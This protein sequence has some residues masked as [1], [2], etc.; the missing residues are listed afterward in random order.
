MK[1]KLLFL[2]F[3]VSTILSIKGNAQVITLDQMT[4]NNTSIPDCSNIN[5]NTD[6][7]VNLSFKLKVTKSN[8]DNIENGSFKHR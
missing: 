8:N 3:C 7:N 4:V 5:F 6:N 2:L 1:T